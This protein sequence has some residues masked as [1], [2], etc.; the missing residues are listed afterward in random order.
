MS[1]TIDTGINPYIY[2]ELIFNKGTKDTLRDT[3]RKDSGFFG[4]IV[5]EIEFSTR[6]TVINNNKEALFR[7][8]ENVHK[9]HM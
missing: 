4:N 7:K 9:L 5:R 2:R 6:K 1:R 8:E 3:P